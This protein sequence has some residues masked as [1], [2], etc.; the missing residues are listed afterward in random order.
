MLMVIRMIG[1]LIAL[2]AVIAATIVFTTG[3][4]SRVTTP[5]QD[6]VEPA[7]PLME[8]V[9]KDIS[10]DLGWQNTGILLESGETIH[11]QFVSGEI[12]DG[13]TIIRG[14]SGVGWACE[15]SSCCEPMP[16]VGRDALIGRVGD[17]LFLV[18]DQSKLTV[19]TGG[20]LQLRINDCDAGLF[21][22]SGSLRIKISP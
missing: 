14:L 8:P 1:L 6:R 2:P 19:A 12:S 11:I 10:A 7:G 3:C 9:T 4:S 5:Y 22:N 13:D 17:E 15:D 20:E 18:G 16:D 21:D